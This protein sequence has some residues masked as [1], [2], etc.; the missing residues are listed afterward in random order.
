M[1]IMI[2]EKIRII[3]QLRRIR[4][5]ETMITDQPI[6]QHSDK[7]DKNDKKD[8]GDKERWDND[9]LPANW[10]AS[11]QQWTQFFS[12]SIA[13]ASTSDPSPPASTTTFWKFKLKFWWF[14]RFE[15]CPALPW[16]CTMKPKKKFCFFAL[17]CYSLAFKRLSWKLAS[18]QRNRS[19]QIFI[20]LC[21]C[22]RYDILWFVCFAEW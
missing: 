1:S 21:C 12:T 8:E 22:D 4:N 6:R 9:S 15:T 16:T 18:T 10:W 11:S 5:N 17:L 3:R 20:K 13:G 14:L 2:R 7:K 19:K